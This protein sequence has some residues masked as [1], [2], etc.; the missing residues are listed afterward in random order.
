MYRK[1]SAAAA[2]IVGLIITSSYITSAVTGQEEAT[3]VKVADAKT[4]L[5]PGVAHPAVLNPSLGGSGVNTIN[6]IPQ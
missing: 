2:I 6:V 1:V 4:D 3:A 5:V